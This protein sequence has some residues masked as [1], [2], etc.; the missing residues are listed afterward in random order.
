M[1]DLD[2]AEVIESLEREAALRRHAARPRVV[3][4]C[5]SCGE[6]PAHVTSAGVTWR[7]CADCAAE[8]LAM[9]KAA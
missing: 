8:H 1:D 5:E 4:D 9:R 6:V 7:F 3:P 2:R